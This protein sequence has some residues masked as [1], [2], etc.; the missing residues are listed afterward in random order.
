MTLT[1]RELLRRVEKFAGALA[2]HGVQKGDRVVVYM[3]MVPE[4]HHAGAVRVTVSVSSR[5]HRRLRVA[6]YQNR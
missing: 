1:Y 6:N 3:P 4:V 2:A 5:H